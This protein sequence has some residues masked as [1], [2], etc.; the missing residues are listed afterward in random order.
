MT[1][2][3]TCAARG[4]IN[5]PVRKNRNAVWKPNSDVYASWNTAVRRKRSNGCE[6]NVILKCWKYKSDVP[7]A[8]RARCAAH[9][10]RP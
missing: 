1:L 8:V 7:V 4:G 3:N 10:V 2:Q 6:L 9:L 5:E